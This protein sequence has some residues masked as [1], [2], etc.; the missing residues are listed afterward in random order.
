LKFAEHC[1]QRAYEMQN[2]GYHGIASPNDIDQLGSKLHAMQE[3][4][5]IFKDIV[6]QPN[7]GI[8][9]DDK[10]PVPIPNGYSHHESN[11]FPEEQRTPSMYTQPDTKKRRGVRAF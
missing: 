3:T 2:G 11:G 6:T 7:S 8:G 5:K 10:R 4:L 9:P 1:K